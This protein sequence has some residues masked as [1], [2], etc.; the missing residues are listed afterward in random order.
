M[1]IIEKIVCGLLVGYVALA[2]LIAVVAGTAITLV[3]IPFVWMF[4]KAGK[5]IRTAGR[6]QPRTAAH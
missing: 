2:W 4:S 5:A 1:R 3:L 6:N